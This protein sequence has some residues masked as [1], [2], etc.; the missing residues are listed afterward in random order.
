MTVTVTIQLLFTFGLLTL[1]FWTRR[2]D[3]KELSR[4]AAELAASR[5]TLQEFIQE[6]EATFSV[7]SRMVHKAEP[8][9]RSRSMAPV[10]NR[11][12]PDNTAS[13]AQAVAAGVQSSASAPVRRAASKKTQVLKLAD[14]GLPAG[15]IASQLTIP[16]GEIDLILSLN[17]RSVGC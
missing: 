14:K 10:V 3:K 9:N 17:G 2:R 13:K 1:L 4:L 7:F 11:I 16:Q 8:S 15:E 6:T 12:L 5:A